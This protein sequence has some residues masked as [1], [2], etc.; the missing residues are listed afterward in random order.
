MMTASTCERHPAP[1]HIALVESGS[2]DPAAHTA[3]FA[4][5]MHEHASSGAAAERLTDLDEIT[6]CL[7]DDDAAPAGRIALS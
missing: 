3:S 5:P 7:R 1:P 2:L 6:V 4:A